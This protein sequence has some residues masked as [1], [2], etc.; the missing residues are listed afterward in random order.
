M[1]D[2]CS[3]DVWI[4]NKR[5]LSFVSECFKDMPVKCQIG[6][7]ICVLFSSMKEENNYLRLMNEDL[8][9][10]LRRSEM[11]L[12]RVNEELARYR[13]A[14]GKTPHLDLDEEQRLRSK[15]QVHIG[16]KQEMQFIMYALK[17]AQLS[18]CISTFP[19]S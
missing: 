2:K 1:M 7:N 10:K 3:N 8:M 4:L 11:V 14:D 17:L 15:L 19:G 18:D 6:N 16:V 13:A 12:N 5:W 9:S